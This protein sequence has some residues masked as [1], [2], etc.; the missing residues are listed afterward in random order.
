MM[1]HNVFCLLILNMISYVCGQG[2]ST[3][4][5][6][7]G[8]TPTMSIAEN[9]VAQ[10]FI[11]TT[12]TTPTGPVTIP[13]TSQDTSH[14]TVSPSQFVYDPSAPSVMVVTVTPVRDFQVTADQ[15]L[16]LILGPTSSS[17][18]NYVGV[19]LSAD[20]TVTN[21]DAA[22]LT[23]S[24]LAVV[25]TEDT[26][27]TPSVQVTVRLDAIPNP[28]VTITY[29]SSNTAIATVTP[30]T[31]AFDNSDWN[32]LKTITITAVDNNIDAADAAFT[33]TAT[34]TSATGVYNGIA[35]TTISGTNIDDDTHGVSVNP[36]AGLQTFEDPAGAVAQ[37]SVVL[38][39]EP[40]DSVTCPLSVSPARGTL[41]GGITQVA[42]T[43]A[44]WA[45]PQ[46]ISVKGVDDSIDA[47]DQPYKVIFG[48]CMSTADM[49]Y[50][51]LSVGDVDLTNVDNDAVGI[52]V[53]LVGGA[54][55]TE[56]GGTTTIQFVLT[57][58]PTGNVI[59]GITSNDGTEGAVAAPGSVTFTN[60]DWNTIKQIVITGQNDDIDDGDIAYKIM[61]STS[62]ADAL[63]RAVVIPDIDLT[64]IDDDNTEVIMTPT[65]LTTAED[66]AVAAVEFTIRLGSA[67]KTGTVTLNCVSDDATEGTTTS[68]SV[69]FTT[70]SWNTL[71]TV[72]VK[73]VDDS[74]DDGDVL[75]GIDCTIT[76]H[77]EYVALNPLTKVSVTNVDN[78][79][80]GITVTQPA[81]R[82]T[83]EGG[84]SFEYT[85]Q[86]TSMPTASVTVTP[87]VS[88]PTEASV[89]PT[90]VTFDTANW[91][92]IKTITV[93]GVDDN[94]VDGNQAIRF[95]NLMVSNVACVNDDNDVAGIIVSPASGSRTT[96]SGGTVT[97]TVSLSAQPTG[98]TVTVPITPNMEGSASP[99][100][101]TFS[102]ADW[103]TGMLVT[104]TG[105]DDDVVDGDV[106][107]TVAVGPSTSTM[108]ASFTNLAG[109]PINLVNE[110]NDV[111]GFIVTPTTGLVTTEAGTRDSFT[112]RLSSQPQ[113][114]RP[115]TVTYTSSDAT[116][117]NVVT[118]NAVF[119]DGNWAT[120]QTFEVEGI[121]DNIVDGDVLYS[122]TGSVST[123]DTDYRLV[124]P[125]T[126]T[127]TNTDVDTLGWIV[128]I[129]AVT[130]TT[131][132]GGQIEIT[133]RLTSNP[134]PGQV[135]LDLLGDASEGTLSATSLQFTDATWMTPQ[136]VTVT[137]IP[138]SVMDGDIT[139]NLV[140]STTASSH[141]AYRGV[142]PQPV[143][144]TNTDQDTASIIVTN[145]PAVLV[146]DEG[147]TTATFS[148]RLATEPI[149]NVVV[150]VA[151]TMP[152]EA[153]LS[154]SS[155]TFTPTNY[156]VD[157]VVTITGRDDVIIDGDQTHSITIGPASST[158]DTNYDGRAAPPITTTNQ[159][160]DSFGVHVVPKSGTVTEAGPGTS[161]FVISLNSQP[162]ADVFVGV[163]S[164][165][166]EQGTIFPASLQ[167]TPATWNVPQTLTVTAVDDAI[168]DG[169]SNFQIDFQSLQSN[170]PDYDNQNTAAI[171]MIAID[172]D[173]AGITVLPQ[174]ILV[175]SELGGTAQFTIVL[176][177]RPSGTNTVRYTWTGD[178]TE[179]SISP[180]SVLFTKDNWNIPQD[181][182]ITG[183]DDELDDNDQTYII[184]AAVTTVDPEYTGLAVPTVTV[185]NTDDDTAGVTV[186]K[187]DVRT[188]EDGT[189]DTFTVVLT[190]EPVSTVETQ[191]A[192]G[193]AEATVNPASL[194]FTNT[195]W[196][197][198]Q[199]VTVTGA[200]DSVIDGNVGYSVSV[201]IQTTDT[202]YASVSVDDI[203]G[204][205]D[206][207]DAGSV[208]VSVVG[209]PVTSEQATQ[210]TFTMRLSASP[211]SQVTVTLDS[212]TLD[213]TEGSISQT[214][215]NF[216]QTNWQTNVVFTV[217]GVND[218]MN[219]GD[220]TY[221]LQFT[222]SSAD[223]NFAALMVQPVT[224]TNT[225]DDTAGVSVAYKPGGLV[226]TEKGVT[227]S[228][229]IALNSQPTDTVTIN[230]VSSRVTEAVVVG[231]AS[232]TFTPTDWK[233]PKAI[234]VQ[235]I[236][237][238][239]AD[240]LA[241][242]WIRTERAVSND[243]VYNDW[244]AE[245]VPGNNQDDD[246]TGY[247]ITPL[248]NLR[249]TELG[250]R[251]FITVTLESQPIADVTIPFS[252]DDPDEASVSPTSLVFT[253]TNWQ[254]A[255]TVTVTGVDDF[256]D[257]DD[258]PFNI[259]VG[260]FVSLDFGYDAIAAID[261]T[262]SLNQDDETRGVTTAVAVD[263][264][265]VTE[266]GSRETFTIVLDTQP[267]HDVIIP[268]S[269]RDATEC[270]V[271]DVSVTFNTLNWNTPQVITV[272][273][274]DDSIADG[275]ISH[276]IDIGQIMSQDVKYQNFDPPVDVAVVTTDDDTPQIT[277]TP[278][279]GLS[280]TEAGGTAIFTI[281]ISTQPMGSVTIPLSTSNANE[282]SLGAVTQVVFTNANWQTPQAVTV[283]GVDDM[284]D[285]G[286]VEYTIVT[287]IVVAP[288]DLAYAGN[289]PEDVKITNTD[290]EQFG[291]TVSPR[292]NI[293]TDEK[294]AVQ[295]EYTVRLNTKPLDTVRIA[296]DHCVSGQMSEISVTPC[297]LDFTTVDWATEKTVTLSGIDDDIADGDQTV[298][299]DMANAVSALDP[300]YNGL[301][302][303]SV[304]AINRDDDTVGINV[305]PPTGTTS[306]DGTQL[307]FTIALNSEPT[308]DVRI[309]IR[310][311]QSTEQTVSPTQLLFTKTDWKTPKVVTIIGVDDPVADGPISNQIEIQP[312]DSLDTNYNLLDS[313]DLTVINTDND[314]A[315]VLVSKTTGSVTEGG[316]SFTFTVVLRTEPTA[317]VTV[318]IQSDDTN[319]ATASPS[320][321][322]FNAAN[323]AV[324]TT[325]T[326]TAVDDQIPEL[327]K[328][329][330]INLGRGIS[331]DDKY[332][333]IPINDVTVNIVD[334]DRAEL[335]VTPTSGLTTSEFGNTAEFSV[336]LTAAPTV[337]VI[338]NIQ[339]T[340]L[341]EG[342]VSVNSLTFTTADYNRAQT[343]TVT[344]VDDLID[345][346]DVDYKV[347]LTVQ[348]FDPNY[349]TLPVTEV[350]ITNTDNDIAG[351]TLAPTTIETSE[352]KK[353][354]TFTVVLNTQPVADVTAKVE[355]PAASGG[356]ASVATLSQSLVFTATNWD[357]PQVV[358]IIGEDDA[359]ADGDQL[360]DVLVRTETVNQPPYDNVRA[361]AQGTNKD[362]DTPGIIVTAVTNGLTFYEN[363][364]AG[365]TSFTFSVVLASQPT[366]S[367]TIPITVFPVTRAQ[368]PSVVTFTPTDWDTPKDVKVDAINN[369]I[370]DGN[371]Y[372]SVTLSEAVS[373]DN[374]YSK[375]VPV[376]DVVQ[377]QVMDDDVAAIV[378]AY[379]AGSNPPLQTTEQGGSPDQLVFVTL[380]TQP[381]S[382][383]TVALT[384]DTPTEGVPNI[385]SLQFTPTDYAVR[386][387][388]T[389]TGVDDAIVDGDVNYNILIGPSSSADL[390]YSG[391]AA[392]P[393]AAT[394]IDNDTPSITIDAVAPVQT[395]EDLG[396]YTIS[397]RLA[398]MPSDNV[399]LSVYSTDVTEGTVS[400]DRLNFTTANWD[401][402]QQVIVTGVD[403]LLR[404]G[405]IT[406]TIRF[407]A[408][409]NDM[410]YSGVTT[411]VNIINRDNEVP[412]FT[413]DPIN[414]LSTSEWGI[415]AEF[416]VVLN[417]Q[418]TADVQIIP[419]SNTPTE[420]TVM[421]TSMIFTTTDWNIA[422]TFTV[423]GVDDPNDD[424]DRS[425]EIT[426]GQPF[427]GDT[428]YRNLRPSSVSVSNID[429]DPNRP[430]MCDSFTPQTQCQ[431]RLDAASVRCNG[432]A[433][434][435]ATCCVKCDTFSTTACPSKQLRPDAA[436][437]DCPQTG[438]DA[439]NCCVIN[440][441]PPGV[442]M[443]SDH[444]P[445]NCQ[446]YSDA[447][448]IQCPATGC[449][450][451]A[452]CVKCSSFDQQQCS[453]TGLLRVD[454]ADITCGFQGCDEVTCCRPS[455]C[456]GVLCAPQAQCHDVGQC[457]SQ[458]GLC[459]TVLQPDGTFCDD[460]DP[461]TDKDECRAGVCVGEDRCLNVIC[462]P[463]TACHTAGVC[464]PQT[465]LC[466][467]DKK[468]DGTPCNDGLPETTDDKCVS[469]A[470]TG[471]ITCNNVACV[472]PEPQCNTVGCGSQHGTQNMVNQCIELP[473]PDNT[474]C[475]DNQVETYDDK[476]QAGRCVGVSRCSTV[477][478]CRA[479]DQCH[480][481][482]ECHESNGECTTPVLPDGTSCDDGDPT[483]HKDQCYQ[484]T[485]L[486]TLKCLG[487][488]CTASDQCHLSGTCDPT[489]GLCSDPVSPSGQSCNDGDTFTTNDKCDGMGNCV[490]EL[491]CGPCQPSE[492]QC[493][494]ARCDN[495]NTCTEIIRPNNVPC[496]D[497][498]IESFNDRCVDGTC[499][500][501]L[502]CD[503]V[504]CQ[505]DQCH[506]VGVCDPAT[507]RCSNPV[508]VD[509]TKCDDGLDTTR[510]DVC[511]S[512]ICMGVNKCLGV[513]C[514]TSGPCRSVGDCV[515]TTGLCTDPMIRDGTPCD[516][517]D[518]TT[519]DICI[520]G[521]CTGSVK[522]GG[523]VCTATEPQC[524]RS[525][526]TT[527]D[528][529]AEVK[530]T[531]GTTCNDD[532]PNTF[533][534][535]CIAGT[536]VG[537]DR[538]A[539]VVCSVQ[540][541]C[542]V[543]GHCDPTTGLCS[544]GLPKPDG[545]PC[546][547]GDLK[548]LNDRCMGGVCSG[549]QIC[550]TITCPSN[551]QCHEAGSCNPGT[552]LC[553]YPARADGTA[554]ND[555]NFE[556]SGDHCEAAACVGSLTCGTTTCQSLNP[557]CMTSICNG[558][559]C[560]EIAKPDETFCNDGN[561]ST[562]KDVCRKGVCVGLDRCS[563]VKCVAVDQCHDAGVCHP[564]TGICSTPMSPDGV[565]CNDGL[566]T[567]VDDK[568]INGVCIGIDK[569]ENV[570]CKPG[571]CL[572]AGVCNPQTGV[573]SNPPEPDGKVCD[574]GDGATPESTCQSGACVGKLPCGTNTCV[575][576]EPQC[577]FPTCENGNQCKDLPKPDGSPC[578]DGLSTTA[579]D[580]CTSGICSGIDKC[581]Q[582]TCPS[583]EQCYEVG[584]CDPTTG[585]CYRPT[586]PD[587]TPCD[588]GI[589][590]TID[591]I[592]N[593]GVC[594]G[595]GRC[596][597]VVCRASDQCHEQGTCDPST[598]LCQ[599]LEKP[600]GFPCDDNNIDTTDD[601]CIGGICQGS[602]TCGGS[603]C[604]PS[605]PECN[606]AICSG[607]LCSQ[608]QVADGTD[609]NDGRADTFN[610]VC[611]AGVCAGT[612]KC[613][614]V[615]CTTR[616]LS[617]CALPGVCEPATG[618]CTSPLVA[619]GTPCDD[620]DA[621]TADD[622]CIGG[623][624]V[625]SNRCAQIVC[626]RSDQCHEVGVCD[627]AT[628]ICTDPIKP[629]GVPCDD[630][631]DDSI[632]D[633]CIAGACVG[634]VICDNKPFPC[635]VTDAQ[636]MEAKCDQGD[637]C[638][639]VKK[640]NGMKCNDNN[641]ATTEDACQD[642]VCV[643]IGKCSTKVCNE[644][645]CNLVGVCDPIS[646]ECSKPPKPDGTLCDDGN[647]LTV[648]DSCNNGACMGTRK[649]DGI[650]CEGKTDCRGAGTCDEN[651]GVCRYVH[652]PDGSIC[653]DRNSATIDDKCSQGICA[654]RVPCNGQQCTAADPQCGIPVCD[655]DKCGELTRADGTA[656]NDNDDFT[657]DD[658]CQQGVCRGT[659]KCDGITCFAIDECHFEG[660]CDP[661]TG[662]CT[663]PIKPD[664]TDCDDNNPLTQTS[665]CR[666]GVCVSTDKC[667]GKTCSAMGVC[668][669]VG[670]C[671]PQTGECSNPKKKDGS[672]CDD[673]DSSTH[674]DVCKDGTCA[675]ES[676]CFLVT[677]D[678]SDSCH[679]PG[680]CDPATGLCSDPIKPDG[681]SCD[682]NNP[683]TLSS[684]CSQGSCVGVGQCG[685]NRCVTS[686]AQCK[687]ATCQGNVC[688][689]T[690]K[691]DGTSCNDGDATTFVDTCQR[692][693]CSG[694]SNCAS[695]TCPG[696][697]C[698]D[699]GT[700]DAAT[701]N[702]K[703]T[704]KVDGIACDDG[705]ANTIDDKCQAG[706]CVGILKC[707]G[708]TCR[709]T[710]ACHDA[711]VCDPQTGI[712][713]DPPK[714]EGSICDDKNA[715]TTDDRC[716]NAVCVGV[717]QCGNT[718]CDNS[719]SQCA[720]TRCVNDQC[721]STNLPDNTPCNDGNTLS[722]PD[723]CKSGVCSGTELCAGVICQ[724]SGVCR[725]AGVC[726]PLTGKC[727][728][729]TE[730]DGVTCDDGNPNTMDDKC[731]GGVC[732]GSD[733]CQGVTCIAS[734]SCHGV[735]TC[736]PSTGLCSDPPLAA[737]T[738][739]DDGDPQTSND[740]CGSGTCS[741][742]VVCGD[743]KRCDSP[744]P[745][746]AASCSG[747]TCSPRNIADGTPCNDNDVLT[748]N[749]VCKE[750]VCVGVNP[751]ANSVC[752]SNGQCYLPGTCDPK[753][754]VCN[755]LAMADGTTCDDGNTETSN[756][757]CVGG[758]CVGVLKCANVQCPPSDD[759][760]DQGVCDPRTGLCQDPP[761]ASGTLCDD[762]NPL[763]TDD[764]CISGVCTGSLTCGSTVCIP[765]VPQCMIAECSGDTCT[766]RNRGNGI[767]CNDNNPSTFGDTCQ[768]GQCV[769]IDKCANVN[770]QPLTTCHT[771]G[772]CE[773]STGKCTNPLRADGSMC[774]DKN[775]ATTDDKCSA[776]V[777]VGA[778]KC[779]N[780]VCKASDTCHFAGVCDPQT[781]LCS[782][783]PVSGGTECDDGNP[784]T[785][786]D[787]CVAGVC[788]GTLNC[789]G[790]SFCTV[791]EPACMM[792]ICQGST[793]SSA[794][795][796]DGT[797]C[798]DNKLSTRDDVCV[799]GVCVGVEKCFGVVC[800]ASD[801]C[802]SHGECNQNTGEC[803]NPPQPDG[804]SCDGGNPT[805]TA[806]CMQGACQTGDK[807]AGV[808]CVASDDCHEAGVCHP[809]TGLCTDPPKPDGVLCNDKD[810]RTTNDVCSAGV[811][812]GT[813]TCNRAPC[814]VS[815]PTCMS[816]DC[817]FGSCREIPKPDG[818]PC[819][820]G[821]TETLGDTCVQGKCI[822]T[823]L[824]KTVT[825]S[826]ADQ[827]HHAGVCEPKTGRCTTP[828]KVDGTIC[829]D[830]LATTMDDTCNNGQCRGV[831]KCQGVSCQQGSCF[832][833]GVCIPETGVCDST[834]YADGS[835]C[836]D[837]NPDSE[838]D[839]CFSG[840]CEGAIRKQCDTYTGSCKL[841]E[842]ASTTDC[843]LWGSCTAELC[844][845]RQLCKTFDVTCFNPDSERGT[846]PCPITGCN[847]E[848][849]C[850]TC[851]TNFD[852]KK[853]P[854]REAMVDVI[855][856]PCSEA[857]CCLD[858]DPM[859]M[860]VAIEIRGRGT[861]DTGDKAVFAFA[862]I[863]NIPVDAVSGIQVTESRNSTTRI[864]F[865][866][867][868][869]SR[870]VD[871]TLRNP[872]DMSQ[873]WQ[874]AALRDLR[875]TNSTFLYNGLD[876]NDLVVH[877][878]NT[879]FPRLCSGTPDPSTEICSSTTQ[880]GCNLREICQ[881]GHTPCCCDPDGSCD[882]GSD[883]LC[884]VPYRE[885]PAGLPTTLVCS[886][887]GLE[888]CKGSTCQRPEDEACQCC[889][890]GSDCS[891]TNEKICC[892]ATKVDEC[893]DNC[894]TC[895]NAD[896]RGGICSLASSTNGQQRCVDPDT[897]VLSN[898][899]CECEPPYEGNFTV[900][901]ATT[902]TLSPQA[903]KPTDIVVSTTK[904]DAEDLRKRIADELDANPSDVLA[905]FDSTGKLR[906]QLAT[907]SMRNAFV[908]KSSCCDD[909]CKDTQFCIDL[910]LTGLATELMECIALTDSTSCSKKV[911]CSYTTTGCAA[912]ATQP[913]FTPSPDDDDSFP[914]W[915]IFV[916]AGIVLLCALIFFFVKKKNKKP[917]DDFVHHERNNF[918]K[919]SISSSEDGPL[920]H[921]TSFDQPPVT[922]FGPFE[923]P[924]NEVSLDEV[925]QSQTPPPLAQ[926]GSLSRPP[927][928]PPFG[929]GNPLST[930]D[931]DMNST[932]PS[933]TSWVYKPGQST[934]SIRHL[935]V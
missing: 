21:V 92:D 752:P 230:L 562:Y 647:P 64:N 685:G 864:N 288:A 445:F 876:V 463:R 245:D 102:A 678:A 538:C 483:T 81:A 239:I 758:T 757:Q 603:V 679:L 554:C 74:V 385:A 666:S 334:N 131:E 165:V 860:K 879:A 904:G 38:T 209:N 791:P 237:D 662:T 170:D 198:P 434:D 651:T 264:I 599:D 755:L 835:Q 79:Q 469:G 357:V 706:I 425:Y 931:F 446:L 811:C 298:V 179:G 372:V 597:G 894:P 71:H 792:P 831:P 404:D 868:R 724:S 231:T 922:N 206:D 281:S 115:V 141:V 637:T 413:V 630:G 265:V 192:I 594:A 275:D 762:G 765:S 924:H 888:T 883:R 701:G 492:R 632:N 487:V 515:P 23:Y 7:V 625:G 806:Q 147:G 727:S 13:V 897:S 262:G 116:E 814:F 219:D 280:T 433:C 258:Q 3:T 674:S 36:T 716:R 94:I 495:F 785:E 323:W 143:S 470:C 715:D 55:T 774:D 540:N 772:Y 269:V 657:F 805:V 617:T 355:I 863:L 854:T 255:L 498:D 319:Q 867:T 626:D 32:T 386:K 742:S 401:K 457:D 438:C 846:I 331:T 601:K 787:R 776:G 56:A 313:P 468:A 52:S 609:C 667:V 461:Q 397:V 183:L 299:I 913:P 8:G 708:V 406:Y 886:A 297:S 671:D 728:N 30:T 243:A 726:E 292:S 616:G 856:N 935:P 521:V 34:Y 880:Y 650:V 196:M 119:N 613:D 692:G 474:P 604:T 77:A 645:T 770:C 822:G 808:I 771:T 611:T 877:P 548:T 839:R 436:T 283:T 925:P 73:G 459:S 711:G 392:V 830:G 58:E 42:F 318:N 602:T 686:D 250:G 351:L 390:E 5:P 387:T 346:G 697:Q 289:N 513:V 360:F 311:S 629:N 815:D 66:P 499:K 440:P 668:Y 228:F 338:F 186:S 869:S 918:E 580:V 641:E 636:C 60:A 523:V 384:S 788:T 420:G 167:F 885:C 529:C 366:H 648:K 920:L 767:A 857:R 104:I 408:S 236:Q 158:T 312:A 813:L 464:D 490:G 812:V 923:T 910:G 508:K 500:G 270:S 220:Q 843:D 44:D 315:G 155:I 881:V 268:I 659:R 507:G 569:C 388:V 33:I 85:L 340:M 374:L 96:E 618:K 596:E 363:A 723:T 519:E 735:G 849:C 504:V 247:K 703:A 840:V 793:C 120:P 359:I 852:I 217:T 827:C 850:G 80:H 447:L 107:Y 782:D 197:R 509:N 460:L 343:I 672:L 328:S 588:D 553:E 161:E 809:T 749:D 329:I 224:I 427:T 86:L 150:P 415:Q 560:Q 371:E 898:W 622:K 493:H 568:C 566:S 915:L 660:T 391:L 15:A 583:K 90:S 696:G 903:K 559:V 294:N 576:Q 39:S 557:Q 162:S 575:A 246:T 266:A 349:A 600:G 53:S 48:N 833:V 680:A 756:D 409:T 795:K 105:L 844:C 874:T 485:C 477:P 638:V 383:V 528:R 751:C 892:V 49:N 83:T 139:Y 496:N 321:I 210:M 759:C 25:V 108:D 907:Q 676:R 226:T 789:G 858:G 612:N 928:G 550:D 718:I 691:P 110:D 628:G 24:T 778:D 891:S 473:K 525:Y 673:N 263:P 16:T 213:A 619:D 747:N 705:D 157:V 218:D 254:D 541:Q 816:A 462:T 444:T 484:G 327:A 480:G 148:V 189:T 533:N 233:T 665:E 481:V 324:E 917:T 394:N 72:T 22:T 395:T 740:V 140:G 661:A 274:Q 861:R 362:N 381:R 506:E 870:N 912:A 180:T 354:D 570:I 514:P 824:C 768:D 934:S 764:K 890:P 639:E 278:T 689:E 549:K 872:S 326:V 887:N 598:G 734:D 435:A 430:P 330:E 901:M 871:G 510:D 159:D 154:M 693:I 919:K 623:T 109:T 516:D 28:D 6:L 370:A 589:D 295:G 122:L 310:S 130:T 633:Q 248:T 88:Q 101:V 309:P 396:T 537:T 337:D 89:N 291:I 187:T 893:S 614:G 543:V 367:V 817:N 682:D 790:A 773:P 802:H 536:C 358:T 332:R 853:C 721:V 465:G 486:G 350:T 344:G 240:G 769:G 655:A 700:C 878:A 555:G 369:A 763:T 472:A 656:C 136:T 253:P 709:A 379:P 900:G 585:Q 875:E 43:T 567:T 889:P 820:D 27:A 59:I 203:N 582:V 534:D 168:A 2:L 106:A 505:A 252:S 845:E 503:G 683:L 235:G 421:P 65:T 365:P 204:I 593:N 848:T 786:N 688:V 803:T 518:D 153:S 124:A 539:G 431:L 475:D 424:G 177:S 547:D 373:K 142:P 652:V 272:I 783:P 699:P 382:A 407:E 658:T 710:D 121:A 241:S 643:G 449:T 479:K 214:T 134:T 163:S 290:D 797:P 227:D 67:P 546:D 117:G 654:G 838:E 454:A 649:C 610:D 731:V 862:S 352:D 847:E 174:Q 669:D 621:T 137:G 744:G 9:G 605:N 70:G 11:V 542:R 714:A 745:C 720:T 307:T 882:D 152:D 837:R 851:E 798:N 722:F 12:T 916:I 429:D 146:T 794:T 190:S 738:P 14:F 91:Q 181:V 316:T 804:T 320:S 138:D 466:S 517:N 123:T 677:C 54:T 178:A 627:F 443:C 607:N 730:N 37:F 581:A 259:R 695:K 739:C 229:T 271:S 741:G 87:S 63:Y 103:N 208:I 256:I 866:V 450:D 552:G 304:S 571:L 587:G 160:N 826:A 78:D 497:G 126:V 873:N 118:V 779:M 777:C 284:V 478:F 302:V 353:T 164:S 234:V 68:S 184:T 522:C 277:V 400:T 133:Y 591:D 151:V 640:R 530:R 200:D 176:N 293:Y 760:H 608:R 512:G 635:T 361:T 336:I 342:T 606:Y 4:L 279:T 129:P 834:P 97:F 929:R 921:D 20:V 729:P 775:P 113:A 232:V 411:D 684:Q 694:K 242:Y 884:C 166:I 98:G 807:C 586:L 301:V 899:R 502:L 532:N 491:P 578:D 494:I 746:K 296:I 238:A 211:A 455:F 810:V 911:G 712:C 670:I 199:V 926:R 927:P 796:P 410:Y 551:D 482:G 282:G 314:V 821:L 156:F 511:I 402:R 405:D 620:L 191:F 842:D 859:P 132:A 452:C 335:T 188:S 895:E 341:T 909:L 127:V 125:A 273:G 145:T 573:C 251:D 579:D 169:N 368:A 1:R 95:N 308:S 50:N 69:V 19:Q 748:E 403:D 736:N 565:S 249:T 818:T 743:G 205:N 26:S 135:V 800:R 545:T 93:T 713:T 687:L 801:Q 317:D 267:T 476:C 303:G 574:D 114:G 128:G 61:M 577:F 644:G 418:P 423:V 244:D 276:S 451:E 675:G 212:S 564:L 57:S 375:M 698:T 416:T 182:T 76:G 441:P 905:S 750:G 339:S 194:T 260:P 906:V 437:V 732:I 46:L 725:I 535:Q 717:I 300:N 832:T 908:Q 766:E 171:P 389:I 193:S 202:T 799:A 524:R 828:L 172:N 707:A 836:N 624:C 595:R 419:T 111:A 664:R 526:C 144:I 175:T 690:N 380:A 753:S 428:E 45:T 615:I 520:Q 47:G 896:S 646:G 556:T 223:T 584:V 10:T 823:D 51:G 422:R 84:T 364:I 653:N 930:Q 902:C 761:K 634:T 31:L 865:I 286:D 149:G 829:D 333:F 322:V 527:G 590:T 399:E 825:C 819:N 642:G 17:D 702:C 207:N 432:P 414:G 285:D 471:T 41:V 733:K 663:T 99:T 82:V 173:V 563:N 417:T 933:R 225:D 737:N 62:G 914:L 719:N 681:T 377:A 29:A 489:T 781:G 456:F 780:K 348:T 784:L 393:V 40:T 75:Y 558:N 221:S 201:N 257:D 195:D 631:N 467:E 855:C 592:C 347:Q 426:F 35:A 932:S 345:D 439:I 398:T 305:V 261:I 412:G 841:R 356:E 561:S 544:E 216:D 18:T 215:A 442:T 488:V 376:P 458:T 572:Q 501:T 325:V 100:S 306:E 378:V 287:G 185:T 754:G 704:P 222:T 448:I 112:I 531:D 453:A